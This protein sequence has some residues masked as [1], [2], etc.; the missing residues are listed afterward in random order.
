MTDVVCAART[1]AELR[2]TLAQLPGETRV[3]LAAECYG[4]AGELDVV[5]GRLVSAIQ[6]DNGVLVLRTW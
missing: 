6:R 5:T 1:V 4:P 2:D 3:V